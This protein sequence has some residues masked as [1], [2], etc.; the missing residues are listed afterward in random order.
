MISSSVRVTSVSTKPVSYWKG[1]VIVGVRLLD[2]T[3]L[4]KGP[5]VREIVRSENCLIGELKVCLTVT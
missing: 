1:Q 4:T 3:L 2:V 5:R